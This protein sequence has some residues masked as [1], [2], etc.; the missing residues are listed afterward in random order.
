MCRARVVSNESIE[1]VRIAA[2]GDPGPILCLN[3]RRLWRNAVWRLDHRHLSAAKL[4]NSAGEKLSANAH[5]CVFR[6][7]E[8]DVVGAG[9]NRVTKQSIAIGLADDAT[10]HSYLHPGNRGVD[11]EK[12]SHG[13]QLKSRDFLLSLFHDQ[14]LSFRGRET[15]FLDSNP[16]LSCLQWDT[17]GPV[18]C[19]M[20]VR[21][22]IEEDRRFILI[23]LHD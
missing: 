4:K 14:G 17:K 12:C 18:F 16:V 13:R 3:L 2:T 22:V 10:V 1:V 9:G 7:G 21:N 11:V 8:F 15:I 23:R 6:M 20:P 5:G 19:R